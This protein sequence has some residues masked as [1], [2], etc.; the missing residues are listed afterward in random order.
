MVFVLKC[1]KL[2]AS[3]L[4]K[5]QLGQ[6][7]SLKIKTKSWKNIR[8]NFKK[9]FSSRC[10]LSFLSCFFFFLFFF[11]TVIIPKF[12]PKFSEIKMR[13]RFSRG[14]IK[15]VSSVPRGTPIYQFFEAPDANNNYDENEHKIYK[16]VWDF[17]WE[18][19]KFLKK[20]FSDKIFFW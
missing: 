10:F 16:K 6:F 17:F 8:K 3:T 14:R 9:K 7:K 5:C 20:K 13:C 18:K 19:I 2:L 1:G 12:A 4:Q 15:A 11:E